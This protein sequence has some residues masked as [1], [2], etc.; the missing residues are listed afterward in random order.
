MGFVSILLLFLMSV[1][2]YKHGQNVTSKILV[3]TSKGR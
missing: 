1:P 2:K 3:L